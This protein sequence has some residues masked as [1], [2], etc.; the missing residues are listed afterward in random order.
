M[1]IKLLIIISNIA[2]LSIQKYTKIFTILLFI[3]DIHE[4]NILIFAHMHR[5]IIIICTNKYIA[6]TYGLKMFKIVRICLASQ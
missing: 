1:N 5:I 2:L 6:Y 4:G 3:A